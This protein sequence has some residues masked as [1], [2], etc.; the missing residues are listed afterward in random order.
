MRSIGPL[1]FVV[2]LAVS[3]IVCVIW[4]TKI[5]AYIT[6]SPS[7]I[8]LNPFAKWMQKPAYIV[9]LRLCGVLALAMAAFILLMVIRS[10]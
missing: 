1:L 2:L 4:P 3:G 8:K 5:Q 6:G 9:A 7:Y 10:G